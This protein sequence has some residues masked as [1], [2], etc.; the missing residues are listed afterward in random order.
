MCTCYAANFRAVLYIKHVLKPQ[1][2]KTPTTVSTASLIGKTQEIYCV[3]SKEKD[4]FQ[5][6][7]R[8]ALA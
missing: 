3:L 1:F 4:V 8:E 6:G 7:I 5:V 2:E